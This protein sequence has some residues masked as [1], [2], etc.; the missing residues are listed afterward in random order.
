M[1]KIEMRSDRSLRARLW[2]Q[3]VGREYTGYYVPLP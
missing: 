1:R 3:F 2:L